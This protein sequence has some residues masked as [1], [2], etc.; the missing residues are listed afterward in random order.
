[1]GWI[2]HPLF[3]SLRQ[4]FNLKIGNNMGEGVSTIKTTQR[5]RSSSIESRATGRI[6]LQ[7]IGMQPAAKAQD[8]KVGDTTLWNYGYTD[9]IKDIKPK[10]KT[11]ITVTFENNRTRNLRKDRYV[12]VVTK[13]NKR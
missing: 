10:G 1:M 3:I 12:A 7:G 5:V 8:L 4:K 13:A 2:I 6:H 9:K 11:M